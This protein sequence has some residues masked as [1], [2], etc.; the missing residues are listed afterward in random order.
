MT[1]FH[2][3]FAIG[4][5]DVHSGAEGVRAIDPTFRVSSLHQK[6]TD[7]DRKVF[8]TLVDNFAEEY[9]GARIVPRYDLRGT[10]LALVVRSGIEHR[11]KLTYVKNRLIVSV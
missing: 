9:L 10:A 6:M 5:E 4:Y 8:S 2:S 7:E 11:S 3:L 1:T